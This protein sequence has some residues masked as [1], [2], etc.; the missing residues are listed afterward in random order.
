MLRDLRY[1]QRPYSAFCLCGNG[2]FQK[3]A[4]VPTR[5]GGDIEDQQIVGT[6][7]EMVEHLAIVSPVP[8]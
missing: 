2:L 8:L 3:A 4:Q 5:S 6:M 1:L 7:L